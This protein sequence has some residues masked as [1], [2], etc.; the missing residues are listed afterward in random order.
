MRFVILGAALA[1]AA[2]AVR[3]PPAPDRSVLYRS[4][5]FTLT[6]RAVRQGDLHAVAVGRDHI[7]SS[8]QR[9]ATEVNFKFSLNG[10]DNERV[11]GE[12]HMI[13]LRPRDGRLVTPVYTFGV[14]D[15][16]VTPEPRPAAAYPEEGPVEVTFRLDLSPALESWRTTGSYEPPNGPP[17]AAD[18][19]EGVYVAGNVAPLSWDFAALRPGAPAQLHDPDGDGIYE[20]TLPFEAAFARPQTA[21]G[22][23]IWTLRRDLSRF[24]RH[25]SPQP[26]VDAL[27]QLALEELLELRRED[28]ALDAGG[29]WPGVWTRDLAWSTLLALALVAPEEVRAGLLARV[30]GDGRIVQDSGTGGSWPISTDRVAWALAAWELYAA[31]GDREWLRTAYGVIRRS[32]E[33]DLEVAFDRETGLF[34]GESTFLDW[35][36]QS[37]PRWMEAADIGASQAL[38]TNALHYGAYRALARMAR[39][40]DEPDERWDAVADAVRDGLDEH[41]WQPDRGTYGAYRYGRSFPSLSPRPEMLGEALTVVLGAAGEE[42]RRRMVRRLPVVPFGVPSFW[43]Y[44]PDVPPYHNAGVWPQVVGFH[45]WAAAEAGNAAAVE[46]ALASLYRA[47][48]LF[49]TNK[50]NWVAA[51][52]HFE[53]T[54]VNSDRFQASA[55]AQL[56]TVYRVLFGIRLHAER[57]ELRPFVPQPYRGTRTLVGLRY[58]QAILTITIHGFGDTPREVRLDGRLVPGAE[59]PADLTG[60]HTLEITLNDALPARGGIEL[61]DNVA[62]PAIPAARLEGDRLR[63]EP[64]AGAV[65]YEVVRNGEP[66]SE[67]EETAARAVEEAGVAEYQV[68][69]VDGRGLASFLGE[70][71]RVGPAA[72][73][74]VVE[75]EP[76]TLESA[77]PGHQGAGYARLTRDRHTALDVRISVAAAG[78]YA[79]DARYANGSGPVSYGDKAAARA[80]LVDGRPAGTLLLPQRGMGRWDDWGTTNPLRVW[81]EPGPHTLTIAYRPTHRNMN[82]ETDEALLDH[83]RVTRLAG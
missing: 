21:D 45:A 42:R 41:L 1:L 2:C 72:A 37:Y 11:P 44:V 14:L 58:R 10:E 24:P 64:V 23:V 56:A 22:R 46:H 82:G 52:G 16:P 8:Y 51:T 60:A 27:H 6:D 61:V 62:A 71:V 29:R 9:A 12:D 48:G 59:I 77:H 69:A 74:Q 28:G 63:W 79:I 36:E 35:R 47:A 25:R 40:L 43:P 5:A 83:L 17:I 73:T 33:A 18:D 4:D 81:L 68:R 78:R 80:L 3:T 34:R 31:T 65:R 53:G 76:A 54:E 32:V 57:L 70:P 67:T 19:F 30:D 20:V 66:Y 39:L 13:Y 7:E 55:A 38:G 50:E 49:L 75:P 26:L 15:P